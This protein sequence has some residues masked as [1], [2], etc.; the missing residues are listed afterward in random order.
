MERVKGL[1][2]KL[3]RQRFELLNEY[4]SDNIEFSEPVPWFSHGNKIPLL[5][6]IF[7]SNFMTHISLGNAGK[8]AGTNLR[9][10]NLN[11][12]IKLYNPI[13]IDQFLKGATGN[14]KKYLGLSLKEGGLL[15]PACL[16]HIIQILME[17]APD[18]HPLLL[19]FSEFYES[20]IDK[21]PSKVKINLAL[22]KEALLTSF[23]IAGQD[24]DK[25]IVQQWIPSEKPSC[26]LD[27]LQTQRCEESQVILHDFQ[28]FPGFH[29][30]SKT[31]KGTAI[32]SSPSGKLTVIYADKL[33]LEKLTG[34]DLIYYNVIYNSFI[35]V[36]Y[37]MLDNNGYRPDKQ[38]YREIT[39][40]EKLLK[41][42]NQSPPKSCPDF[43]LHTN[44]FFL[45]LCPRMN[46]IPE[47]LSLSQGM[48]I[49]LE[50]WKILESS[51]KI[52]GPRGGKKVTFDNVGRYLSNTEFAV[53]VAK[54]WVGSGPGESDYL[55]EIIKE[56]L[57]A[58]RAAIYAVKEKI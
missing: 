37:K 3:P 24:F 17:L 48:Y 23:L 34:A 51:G 33:P 49:P 40:I 18:T 9:R 55:E 31:I 8:T 43:R 36:Q 26:F 32:F 5:C 13:A 54:G 25:R 41:S 39:R 6:F 4:A 42:C 50:Y 52:A 14:I 1:V 7:E 19:R 29:A 35:F 12:I 53:L 56:T 47:N 38:L 15:T 16:K 21:L 44:P 2:I 27:G 45:K 28:N 20:M 57:R 46:F 22:Q 30:L 11:N 10:I 58:G